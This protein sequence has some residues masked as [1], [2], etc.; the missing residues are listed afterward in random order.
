MKPETKNTAKGK[1]LMFFKESPW[2]IVAQGNID[3]KRLGKEISE[4]SVKKVE[5]PSK[6]LQLSNFFIMS[7]PLIL[8]ASTVSLNRFKD[9]TLQSHSSKKDQVKLFLLDSPKKV[10]KFS[11][12]RTGN[13]KVY[14]SLFYLDFL[15]KKCLFLQEKLI[16]MSNEGASIGKRVEEQEIIKKQENPF[17]TEQHNEISSN[18]LFI[19]FKIQAIFNL[20]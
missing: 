17:I 4:K 19:F 13:F 15:V 6:K 10:M 1:L 14:F 5:T 2:Q 7:P 18:Y 3:V 16:L 8:S 12:D 9:L 20:I 11:S